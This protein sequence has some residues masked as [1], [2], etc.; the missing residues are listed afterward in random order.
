MKNRWDNEGRRCAGKV[1]VRK[2]GSCTRA[3][4]T[5]KGAG[6]RGQGTGDRGRGTSYR[7]Q[8]RGD[9]VQGTGREWTQ[10]YL[11][12]TLFIQEKARLD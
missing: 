12:Q 5:G 8:G 6:D 9:K 7:G 11:K 4:L 10:F 2:V 3:V 1:V